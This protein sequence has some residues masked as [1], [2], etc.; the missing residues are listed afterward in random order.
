MEIRIIEG[1]TEDWSRLAWFHYRNHR[2]GVPR[3]IFRLVS[4]DELCGVVVCCYPPPICF[5]KR[6]VLP[7]MGMKKLKAKL[8]IIT[9]VVVH[10]KYRTIGLGIKLVK[11]TLP[12]AGTLRG[13]VCSHRKNVLNKLQTL[14][15]GLEKLREAFIKYCYTRFMKYFFCHFPFGKKK[16]YAKGMK[17]AS[18]EKL[19]RLIK[20]C[21]FLM[22]TRF[23]LI[24][25]S[26]ISRRKIWRNSD[27]QVPRTYCYML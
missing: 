3:K 2:A 11:E 27:S 22:Q 16:A 12:L 17:K 26:T 21:G 6:L 1:T 8:S 20:V 13:N 10:P 7:K 24:W 5:G 9:L 18:L 14:S 19:A 15:E 23:H 4:G 25:C